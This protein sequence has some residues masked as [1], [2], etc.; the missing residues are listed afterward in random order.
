M[1]VWPTHS[2]KE[3]MGKGGTE[4]GR[5]GGGEKTRCRLLFSLSPFLPFSFSPII[6][7]PFSPIISSPFSPDARPG[8][9][10]FLLQS[11]ALELFEQRGAGDA[12][13]FGGG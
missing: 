3:N 5:K 4:I 10:A 2:P 1:G 9:L 11:V 8:P 12:E 13:G 7:S 6:S